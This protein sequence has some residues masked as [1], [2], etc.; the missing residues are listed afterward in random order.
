MWIFD[1]FDG[2]GELANIATMIKR[3]DSRGCLLHFLGFVCIIPIAICWTNGW[4]IPAVIFTVLWL[5]IEFLGFRGLWRESKT[6]RAELAE[7]EEQ[8]EK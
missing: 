8:S 2:I 7:K 5:F 3:G 1:L 6:K 4:Y